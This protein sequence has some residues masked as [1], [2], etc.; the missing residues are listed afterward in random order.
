MKSSRNVSFLFHP[1][2]DEPFDVSGAPYCIKRYQQRWYVVI[3]WE[4]GF[5]DTY[6]LDRIVGLHIEKTKFKMDKD[7][8]AQDFFRYSFGVRVNQDDAP[9]TIKLKV[10]SQQCPYFRSLPLHPSQQEIETTDGYSIFTMELVPT[11][12]FTMKILSYGFLVEVLE[13]QNLRQTV[14]TEVASVYHKYFENSHGSQM[15]KE[16]K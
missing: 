7:F 5:K 11:I 12:E 9:S 6:S 2:D 15:D 8:N 16:D 10:A 4:D 3:R 1:F 14:M 13:P